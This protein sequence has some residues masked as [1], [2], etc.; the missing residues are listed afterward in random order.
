MDIF[1]K[2]LQNLLRTGQHYSL[3]LF[4]EET[5]K[6]LGQE[7]SKVYSRLLRFNKEKEEICDLIDML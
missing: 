4:K 2:Y 1:Y 7:I 3:K 6:V 5:M